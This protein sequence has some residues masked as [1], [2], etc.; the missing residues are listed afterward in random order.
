MMLWQY[1][2]L[3][4]GFCYTFSKLAFVYNL[5]RLTEAIFTLPQGYE[6]IFMKKCLLIVLY[7]V[8]W[9]IMDAVWFER[10]A[11]DSKEIGNCS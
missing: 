6:Q 5:D 9:A 11:N 3:M 7:F 2:V 4:T 1:N 8:Y 10:R